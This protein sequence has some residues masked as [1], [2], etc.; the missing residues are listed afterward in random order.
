MQ[1]YHFPRFTLHNVKDTTLSILL[2]TITGWVQYHS[3]EPLNLALRIRHHYH[4]KA[5]KWHICMLSFARPDLPSSI[6]AFDSNSNTI[7]L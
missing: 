1:F 6:Y 4:E 7:N 5:T 2:I 3:Y